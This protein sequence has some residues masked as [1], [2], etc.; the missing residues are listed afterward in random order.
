MFYGHGSH[1]TFQFLSFCLEHKIDPLCLPPHTSHKSQPSDAACFGP[2]KRNL[3]QE[4][5]SHFSHVSLPISRKDWTE[6]YRAARN[7][8]LYMI[9]I[10][11]GFS[12]TEIYPFED[13]MTINKAV[14]YPPPLPPLRPLGFM[15]LWLLPTLKFLRA[16]L[17]KALPYTI[18]T[19]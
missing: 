17:L 16:D 8:T 19:R 3:T 12:A 18:Q 5:D 11:S 1:V 9:T 10:E 6:C 4:L 14:G 15:T 13:E 2:L 7:R